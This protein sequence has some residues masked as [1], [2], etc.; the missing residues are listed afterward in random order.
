MYVVG[1]FLMI[2]TIMFFPY[3]YMGKYAPR[4]SAEVSSFLVFSHPAFALGLM[5]IVYPG[6]IGKARALRSMMSLE[7]FAVF[8][9]VTY[10]TYMLHLILFYFYIASLEDAI[11]FSSYKLF[12]CAI[13]VFVLAYAVSLV[14]TLLFESPVVKLTK[15]L[16]RGDTTKKS[17]AVLKPAEEIALKN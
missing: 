12:V 16:L 13:D 11:Y 15:Y 7:C 3:F 10:C 9:R 6:C 17:P 14:L 4:S 8:A 2:V 1:V 5:L